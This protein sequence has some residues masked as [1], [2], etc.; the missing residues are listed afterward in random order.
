MK[1][2][3]VFVLLLAAT[4]AMAFDASVDTAV[5]SKYIWRGIVLNDHPVFQ[6]SVT[7]GGGGLEFNIWGNMD[8]TDDYGNQY[9]FTEAD[10]TLSY[11]HDFDACAWTVGVITYTFPNTDFASTS[12]A[13]VGVTLTDVPLGPSLTAYYDYDEVEGFYLELAGAHEFKSGLSAGLLLG[14][15]SEDY[16]GAYFD[17]DGAADATVTHYAAS[18]D[19]PVALAVGSL[20]FNLTYTN[21]FDSDIH[22]PGMPDDDANLVVGASWSYS[23]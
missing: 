14:Y 21:L 9:N 19:Y 1:R 8:L 12:E 20:N 7:L 6:P 13:F 22:S 4:Q 16:V 2:L 10:Y 15:G 3:L 11:G 17:T 23:F 18:L 5:N